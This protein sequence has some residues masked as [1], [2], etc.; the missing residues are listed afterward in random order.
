M[1]IGAECGSLTGLLCGKYKKVT[2]VEL[3]KRRA[4]V[5][6]LRYREKD[7]LEYQGTYT[8]SYSPY[9][10]FLVKIKSLLKDDGKLLIA[11]ENKYG[12]KYWCGAGED[13]IGV[14]FDRLNQ[15]KL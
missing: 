12:V 10:D 14:P 2:A 6:Q 11:I 9:K 1:E 13:H 7:N 15:Y 3:S 5:A 4:T 8:D